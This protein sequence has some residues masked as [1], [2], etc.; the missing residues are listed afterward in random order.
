MSLSNTAF[1]QR[2]I[3][4]RFQRAAVILILFTLPS[5]CSDNDY[6]TSINGSSTFALVNAYLIDGTGAGAVANSVVIIEG[7]LIKSVGTGN[8]LHIPLSVETIDL[9]G[10]YILPG[11][12]NTHVHGAYNESNLMEWAKTGVTT[13]RDLGNFSTSPEQGFAFRNRVAD[14][15]EYSRLVAAGPMVT[16]PGGYGNYPVTSVSDAFYK[17]NQLIDQG[18]D[19]IKIAIEDNLQGRTWKMLSLDEIRQIVKTAHSRNRRVAAHISNSIHIKTALEGGVDDV[20]HMTY[21]YVPDSVI[22]SM[23][24]NNIYWIPTLELWKGVSD[25][26]GNNYITIAKN[27]LGRFVKAGG[28]VALGTDFDGYT[29]PF[30]L[31]MPIT[32]IKLMKESGMS[33][34]EIITAGTLNA[35][36]ACGMDDKLGSVVPGKIADLLILRSSPLENPEAFLNIKMVIH[37]GQIIKTY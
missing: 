5:S 15:N 20:D 2:R 23:V 1:S 10:A 27:N 34:M 22:A 19:L 26:Y 29:T 21:D 9:K 33:L 18:A 14:K 25:R 17:I 24:Q 37:N 6:L 8:S 11:L 32:E 36:Y 13:V 4:N 35:A 28:K 16:A 3:L 7:G 31:G 12:M 30:D